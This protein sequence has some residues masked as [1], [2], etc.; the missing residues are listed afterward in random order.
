[1][2]AAP[3]APTLHR[4]AHEAMAT[5]FE[6][7]LAAKTSTKETALYAAQAAQALFAEIDRIEN[8]L[9]HFIS[10]SDISRINHLGAKE[11]VR[12]S[13]YTFECLKIAEQLY[14]QTGG[15]FDVTIGALMACWRTP[16]GKNRRPS[17]AEIDAARERVGMDKVVF[18]K[19]D[20]TIALRKEGVSLDLGGIGKGYALDKA[21]ELL[22]DWREGTPDIT[23]ALLHG[24]E[25]SVL[26]IDAPA[27]QAGWKVSVGADMSDPNP[28]PQEIVLR[29][30]ALSGSGTQLRGK[31][32]ID[33]RTA[34]PARRALRAW[35]STPSA[36]ASDALATAFM[37]LSPAEVKEY[38]SRYSDTWA[39]LLVRGLQGPKFEQFGKR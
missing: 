21:A 34:R 2:P 27:A 39:I 3:Q 22:K 32:I 14:R 23:G 10:S 9:S 19:K 1:M 25:S 26:A 6:V 7:I 35:A 12:V 38:C 31:H 15:V 37:T 16:D 24:G 8:D 11:P 20:L 5:T 29:D 13:L 33:P 30:R 36:T 18:N 4:F 28:P 17:V